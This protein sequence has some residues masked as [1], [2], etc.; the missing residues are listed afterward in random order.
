L[1]ILNPT[2]RV[3][4]AAGSAVIC[5]PLY[6]AHDEFVACVRSIL[7]HTPARVPVLVADDASPDDRSERFLKALDEAGQLD[8]DVYY[9]RSE[10]NRGF[11][12]T[13][14]DAF[15]RTAPADVIVLNSDCV[16][17]SGWFD[18]ITAAARESSLVATV[19]VFTNHGTILSLPHR[20]Q[21]QPDLPQTLDLDRTAEMIRSGSMRVRPRLPTVVGHCFYVTRRALDLVGSFDEAF[22]PGYGEEVDFAQRCVLH[23]LIHVLAD[24]A[25]VLHKGSTSFSVNGAQHAIKDEHD[26]MVAVRYP[27]YDDWIRDFSTTTASPFAR[28][29][30]AAERALRGL[31][32]TIDGRCLTPIVTGTQVH[33]LEV[34]AALSRENRARLRVVVPIDLGDYATAVL[35]EL[36]NVELIAA[37]TVDEMTPR[38]DV[39]HRPFQVSSHADLEFLDALGERVVV[40]HQDLIAFNNPG[41]FTSYEAWTAHR[42]LTR[43]ALAMA[44]RVVFFSREAAEDAL[45]EE[46]VE[47]NRSDVVYIGTDH[48]IDR[49]PAAEQA[50]PTATKLGERPFLLCLGTDFTHK[51]RAFVL[52]VLAELRKRHDWDGGVVFAGPHVPH[53]SSW[54][55]EASF[56]TFNPELAGYVVDVAAVDEGEK[57]WLLKRAALMMYPSVYEGFGLVPFEAADA[58]LVCAFAAQTAVAEL[59]PSSLA[60]IEQWDPEA[61]AE[62]IAPYLSS[63]E[64]REDHIAAVSAAAAPLT[65]KRTGRA[66]FDVY[67]AAAAA[68]VRESRQLVDDFVQ[69]RGS[70]EQMREELA[71][72][73]REL[74][75]SRQEFANLE[76][77]YR[78][79]RAMFDK[80]AE[81]LV[82]PNG[83]IP[84]DL[85]RPLLAIGYRRSL[86]MLVFGPLRVAYRT[87]YRIRHLRRAPRA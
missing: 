59:L 17:T 84:T 74:E 22:S 53:G 50:P 54:S 62:R 32:V 56:L 39:V 44:D 21:P 38:D 85:R 65:W 42:R 47:R 40:T 57:R 36:P 35:R 2:D 71:D 70:M 81:S 76:G 14:N 13:A 26:R 10:T 82:G 41:Y 15:R 77:G 11:V 25:F 30:G 12:A 48:T 73:Q 61:T 80:T 60:L 72:A 68:R 87:G 18:A 1:R 66:L 7:A 58:D 79:F 24:D 67:G 51:N 27:Y 16:V 29:R 5:V 45:R 6:C 64:L 33:T 8:R 63:E 55:E 69:E 78:E 75:E 4:S 28:A 34:I 20:N 37:E 9:R 46:L 86:R 83:V 52:R 49:L 19:S 43:H 23:G 31:K 3:A